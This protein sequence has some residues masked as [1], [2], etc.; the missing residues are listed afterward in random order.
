MA[1]FTEPQEHAWREEDLE[2]ARSLIQGE[3]VVP[4]VKES[5]SLGFDSGWRACVETL[6]RKGVVTRRKPT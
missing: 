2:R 1:S 6:I 3:V 5:Y 4:I